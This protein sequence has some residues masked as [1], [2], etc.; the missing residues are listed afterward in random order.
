M[1]RE[2]TKPVLWVSE[3]SDSNQ[4]PPLQRLPRKLKFYL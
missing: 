4:S 3:K 2:A 1:G